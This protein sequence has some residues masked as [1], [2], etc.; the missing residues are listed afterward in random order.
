MRDEREEVLS[1]IIF[2]E[3]ILS[4]LRVLVS[5]VAL[6]L[7][8]RRSLYQE[9][10][11]MFL[12]P[13]YGKLLIFDLGRLLKRRTTVPIY[14]YYKHATE[15]KASFDNTVPSWFLSWLSL[16][17]LLV[18]LFWFA[19]MMLDDTFFSYIIALLKAPLFLALIPLSIVELLLLLCRSLYSDR[20]NKPKITVSLASQNLNISYT[21][22]S[23]LRDGSIETDFPLD[24]IMEVR[25]VTA[26]DPQTRDLNVMARLDTPVNKE[27][28]CGPYTYIFFLNNED[29]PLFPLPDGHQAVELKMQNGR[30]VLIETSDAE[31][32][33]TAL[34]GRLAASPARAAAR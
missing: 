19:P 22:N 2:W 33:L 13:I 8:I 5:C 23:F 9:S 16:L 20:G 25:I 21:N 32:F 6:P 27:M 10:V 31:N 3:K 1:R 28:F 11:A 14:T 18:L 17:F 26:E 30:Y 34:R 12:V 29:A 24:K 7:L 4:G 15:G